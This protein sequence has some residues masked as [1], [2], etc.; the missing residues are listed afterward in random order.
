MTFTLPDRLL[1]VRGAP[2]G[3]NQPYGQAAESANVQAFVSAKRSL[4]DAG[5]AFASREVYVIPADEAATLKDEMAA[6]ART[7]GLASVQISRPGP[8]ISWRVAYADGEDLLVVD[9][10]AGGSDSDPYL[11]VNVLRGSR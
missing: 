11:P 8:D 4:A 5:Y 7:A 1:D 3:G 6:N 2:F 10:V 9:V